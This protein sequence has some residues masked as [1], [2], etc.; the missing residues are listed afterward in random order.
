MKNLIIF[1]FVI[2]L[3]SCGASKEVRQSEKVMKGNWSLTNVTYS[4]TGDY[5]VTLLNDTSKT[6]F[7]N[8][9]WQFVPNNN[10]GIYT[11]INSDCNTGERNFNFAIQEMDE[12]TGNYDFVLKPT[13]AKGKSETNAGFKFR[14]TSLSENEMQWQQTVMTNGTPFIINMNFT[15]TQ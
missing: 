14:L 7:E 9:Q 12:M 4:K 6:C 1:L 11:I 15:K 2:T 5:N 8:S 3:I 10:T 13:N